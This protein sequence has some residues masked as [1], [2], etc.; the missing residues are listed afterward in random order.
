MRQGEPVSSPWCWG[1]GGTSSSAATSAWGKLFSSM[2]RSAVLESKENQC[3][4]I[5]TY[6]FGIGSMID[7]Q[8]VSKTGEETEDSLSCAMRWK[9]FLQTFFVDESSKEVDSFALES[10]LSKPESRILPL[11]QNY[12][13]YLTD[14][15]RLKRLIASKSPNYLYD[16]YQ[17]HQGHILNQLEDKGLARS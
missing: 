1:F 6:V 8:I 2:N 3:N 15:D 16:P 14:L 12:F 11:R 17:R 7:V 10:G 5:L 9:L 4:Q 13:W